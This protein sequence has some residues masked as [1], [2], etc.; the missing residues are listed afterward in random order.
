MTSLTNLLKFPEKAMKSHFGVTLMT[1]ML[2]SIFAF[3]AYAKEQEK[4]Q[5]TLQTPITIE[6]ITAEKIA[7][8][9]IQPGLAVTYYLNFFKRDL[10]YLKQM[11]ENEFEI[12][13]G[14]P[15]VQLNPQF[16]DGEVF[17]SGTSRGVA[18]SMKG[19]LLFPEQGRYQMQ[20]LSNDGV[21]VI[22]DDKLA[23]SDPQQHSDQLSNLAHIEITAEGWVPV[24]VEYFQRKG[25]SA[26]KLFWKMPG[27]ED[28][29][30]VPKENYGHI[31][32]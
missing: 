26:L 15:V 21:I 13:K 18:M 27:G 24:T 22:I 9:T 12:M 1:L 4:L 8:D 5:E 28:F 10:G 29:V 2:L 23:I 25:T 14:E 11:K 31:P 32:Q 17:G 20:A 30:P 16:G 6:D 3:S 7:P 19:Y